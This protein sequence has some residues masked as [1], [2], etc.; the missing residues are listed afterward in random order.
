MGPDD[1]YLVQ[2]QKNVNNFWASPTQLALGNAFAMG[3]S[4]LR[5]AKRGAIWGCGD[6][7]LNV[8]LKSMSRAGYF[9]VEQPT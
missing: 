7:N 9:R 5:R 6:L 4:W 8:G 1:G 3:A 2:H